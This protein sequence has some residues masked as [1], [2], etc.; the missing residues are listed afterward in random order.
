MTADLLKV[1]P[2]GVKASSP[3][4]EKKRNV[5]TECLRITVNKHDEIKL[6]RTED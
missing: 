5:K 4:V 6:T 3:N 1:S 2:K